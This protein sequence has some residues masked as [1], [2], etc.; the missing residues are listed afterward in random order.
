MNVFNIHALYL[1]PWY[2]AHC[3][4]QFCMAMPNAENP[5]AQRE[6]DGVCAVCNQWVT[7]PSDFWDHFVSCISCPQSFHKK[8]ID[9]NYADTKC[10]CGTLKDIKTN[11]QLCC[12][13][14]IRGPLSLF[15]TTASG[16]NKMSYIYDDDHNPLYWHPADTRSKRRILRKY[17]DYEKLTNIPLH[18][19]LD[20]HK[21]CCLVLL[22]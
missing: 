4:F 21:I 11:K 5:G 19:Q 17:A 14:A 22:L 8:C 13:A 6:V 15:R 10:L 12:T 3:A 1:H 9:G 7:N 20:D 18:F 16:Y 2:H